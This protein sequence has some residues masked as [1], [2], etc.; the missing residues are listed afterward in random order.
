MGIKPAQAELSA[1]FRPIFSHIPNVYLIHD[2]LIIATISFDEHLEALREVM[3]I[4]KIKNL[5]PLIQ[6]NVFL[7]QKK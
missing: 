1:A 7:Q 3:E 4:I 2:D 6:K 5:I